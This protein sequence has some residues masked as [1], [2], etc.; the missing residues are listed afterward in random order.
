MK[1]GFQ[2]KN[3]RKVNE[4]LYRGSRPAARDIHLLHELGI[5]TVVDFNRFSHPDEKKACDECGMRYIHVPWSAYWHNAIRFTYYYRIAEKFLELMSD[6]SL[7]P[8]YVH[9][10][11]GRDRTGMLVAVYRM[12]VENWSVMRAVEEM[13]EFKFNRYLHWDLVRF[14]ARY[15]KILDKKAA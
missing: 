7:Y 1:P 14:L 4:A 11:H 12:A 3:F 9:C 5:R 6:R 10:F 13:K 8:I 2:I 15:R